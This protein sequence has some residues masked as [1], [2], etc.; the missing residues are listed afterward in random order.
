VGRFV[1]AAAQV[2]SMDCSGCAAGSLF[3]GRL[4]A[5]ACAASCPGKRCR[6]VVRFVP[7]Y[8]LPGGCS[9]VALGRRLGAAGRGLSRALGHLLYGAREGPYPWC[10][11]LVEAQCKV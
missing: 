3:E 1:V 11:P 10:V 8:A 2:A 5:A 4:I 7:E 9:Q 6:V